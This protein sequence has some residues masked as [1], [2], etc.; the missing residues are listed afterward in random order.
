MAGSIM[1]GLKIGI[2]YQIGADSTGKDLYD[3]QTFSN[4][5]PDITDDQIVG[6][7][8]KVGAILDYDIT[9]MNKQATY[10]MTRGEV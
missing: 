5:N 6:F 9:T 2:A 3:G 4:V 7:C 10:S 8:D 1:T